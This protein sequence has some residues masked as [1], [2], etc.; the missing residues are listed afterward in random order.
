MANNIECWGHFGNSNVKLGSL[1]IGNDC[2]KE[3]EIEEYEVNLSQG[4]SR[5]ILVDLVANFQSG[6][7]SNS[8]DVYDASL[9]EG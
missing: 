3:K 7:W 6:S 5:A 1:S 9:L 8:P 2:H 4:K